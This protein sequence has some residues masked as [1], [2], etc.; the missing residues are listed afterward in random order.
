MNN[1]KKALSQMT[2]TLAEGKAGMK[3]TVLAE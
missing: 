2:I 3:I 1:D